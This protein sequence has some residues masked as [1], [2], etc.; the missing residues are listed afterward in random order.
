MTFQTLRRVATMD[1]PEL[2]WRGRSAARAAVQRVRCA[3]RPPVWHRDHL[4]RRL[5]NGPGLRDSQAALSQRHW[6]AAHAALQEH[7][8][9]RHTPFVLAPGRR[10]TT[11]AWILR[12]HPHAADDAAGRGNRL[13]SGVHDL[14]GYRGL[15]FDGDWHRDPVS[16]RTAPRTVWCDVPYLDPAC[17]DHK[18][19]WELNR[20]QHWLAWGRA[21]WLTG[22][23]RYRAAFA[24][25]LDAWLEANPPLVGVN[26][27]SMLELSFRSISWIWAL[28]F[29]ARDDRPADPTPWT[30][31]LLL[32]LDAQLT[33]VEHN[34][35][36]YF[37]PNTHLLGEALALYVAGLAL[38][39]LAASPR[40]AALGRRILLQ[41]AARQIADDGGHC[42]RS[43]HYH[44]YTLDFFL[45][46]L[47]TARAADDP[48]A[49]AF[50][51]IVERLAEAARLLA[52]DT[53]R[54]PHLG[55]DDGGMLLPIAGRSP[56]DW[57]DALA[58]AAVLTGRDALRIG[59]VPEETWWTTGQLRDHTEAAGSPPPSGALRNTG[60]Y[61]SRAPGGHHLVVDGGPHGYR[62]GG[63]AH[64]DALSLTLSVR[65]TPLLID[66]GTGCYTIDAAL[67]DRFRSTAAHNTLI[68]DDT[69]QSVGAGPFQWARTTDA[70]VDRWETA[71]QFDYFSGAHDGYGT[72]THRRR[73][74]VMHGDMVIV[75]DHVSGEGVH[76]AAVHWHL[77]EAWSSTV[78]E[79]TTEVAAGHE[80][81]RLVVANGRLEML[82]GDHTSGLGWHSPAYGCVRATTT[83]RVTHEGTAPFAMAT[84]IDLDVDNPIERI[85]W[86]PIWAEAAA[87]RDAAALKITRRASLAYA[88]FADPTGQPVRRVWRAADVETD[89]AALHWRVGPR[90]DVSRLALVDGSY[91][92]ST[93]RP[94]LDVSLEAPARTLFL[95]ELPLR[96]AVCAASPAS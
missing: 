63:H 16:G 65:G 77:D 28:H 29:F 88:L 25:E 11:A 22:D 6:A 92:R 30:V 69:P 8:A 67:R 85:D 32:A 37:S 60:Y 80:R 1:A 95:D 82:K 90:G 34:L 7:F 31:D 49:E 41:E 10:V 40:R 55:D 66:P 75:V 19:I 79:H 52:D 72:A 13:L 39:E 81:A 43:T 84:V 50:E 56:D 78:A 18:V 96:S 38:P 54:V 42:E 12:H 73:V 47:G 15:Q 2:L 20:H 83:I 70:V 26:W 24:R 68:L 35:S 62:N 23:E 4:R 27:A 5:T 14:L 17:G 3:A 59:D 45:L 64:S 53:G 71:N 51:P 21:Y 9:T 58:T 86:L 33:H 94:L 89:A 44:R 74:F 57:R 87:A 76:S 93:R 48:A 36:Y 46:A 61:V 91:V